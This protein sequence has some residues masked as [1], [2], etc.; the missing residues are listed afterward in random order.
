MVTPA[1]DI[2]DRNISI[3]ENQLQEM[4]T[5]LKGNITDL[6]LSEACRRSFAMSRWAKHGKQIRIFDDSST[7]VMPGTVAHNRRE[8]EHD[9]FG[10][11]RRTQRLIGPLSGL[12]PVYSF[13][14]RLRAL[15]IGPRT[16]MELL[17]L[18]GIGFR[19][20]NIRAVDLIASSP[21]MDLGDMHNLPYGDREFD[22]VISG[23]VLT[24][25]KTPERAVREMVRVCKSGGLIAIG[26]SACPEYP[27]GYIADPKDEA[28]IVGSMFTRASDFTKIIGS[29][30]ECVHFQ[31]DARS[32]EITTPVM[33]IARIRHD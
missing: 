32:T 14:D 30:L 4:L 31:Q 24:Y 28:E 7:G 11:S 12:E 19:T 3:N 29:N 22:V 27:A 6:F 10:A 17:H 8:I 33:L 9:A 25:S 18:V 23:W 26:V 16:E 2:Q 20:E 5:L 21:L 1:V 15:S 13:S